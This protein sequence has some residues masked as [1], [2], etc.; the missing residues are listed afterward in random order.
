MQSSKAL[1]SIVF[2]PVPITTFAILVLL[3]ADSQI[4]VTL[5][6]I[7]TETKDESQSKQCAGIAFKFEDNVIDLRA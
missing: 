4:F 1:S 3:K 2:T 6:G 7:V 5:F